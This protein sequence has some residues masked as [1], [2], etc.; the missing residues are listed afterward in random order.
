MMCSVINE[1]TTRIVIA[2]AFLIII[3]IIKSLLT[4]SNTR[5]I[6]PRERFYFELFFSKSD[7]YVPRTTRYYNIARTHARCLIY[8]SLYYLYI[9]GGRFVSDSFFFT[10]FD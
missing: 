4:A 10:Y 1:A 8:I 7:H 9:V 2:N 5:F 6:I 3:T